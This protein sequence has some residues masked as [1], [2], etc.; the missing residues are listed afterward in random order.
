MKRNL[1]Q[2]SSQVFDLL[3]IGGGIYGVCI[4]WDA[5][6]RGLSVA[7]VEKGDF[8][9]ATSANSLRVIHGGLRY[10]QH[11][12][13]PRM[14]QSIRERT[15]FMQIAPHLVQPFPIVIPTYGHGLRGR[16]IFSLALSIDNLVGFDRNRLKDP[17][18][19]LPG[20][21]LL[22][23]EECIRRFPYVEKKRLTGGVVVYDCQMDSS[24][25]LVLSLARSAAAAGAEMANYTEVTELTSENSRVT[26]V[27]ARDALTGNDEFRIRAKVTVNASGPWMDHV[28]GLLP[29]HRG[30]PRLALSRAFN[31]LIRR[32]VIPRYAVGVYG[33]TFYKDSDAF[34]RKGSR[35]YFI[36]P[37]RD[38]SLIGTAHLPH[39]GDPNNVEVTEIEI[40]TFLSDLNKGCQSI[41]LRR[42]DVA[43]VYAGLLPMASYGREGIQLVKH[44]RLYDHRAEGLDGLISVSGV[45]FTE[46]RRVAEKVVNKTFVHLGKPSPK[47]STAVTPVHGGEIERFGT[48]VSQAIERRPMGLSAD[49]TRDLVHNY[50]SAY[51]EILQYLDSPCVRIQPAFSGTAPAPSAPSMPTKGD[52]DLSPV[53]G[54]LVRHA[55]RDEMAKK[56]SDLV[57]RR[58]WLGNTANI[59]PAHLRT[60]AAVMAHELGWHSIKAQKELEDVKSMMASDPGGESIGSRDGSE[61]S[62][63]AAP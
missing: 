57:F 32:E 63:K 55:V 30:Q 1:A 60:C 40:E 14:R 15:V 7:L 44:P 12:D 5:A 52:E 22:S 54:A 24:E 38:R 20:G 39:D 29:G 62:V 11:G 18:K 33:Q 37:W 9:H 47:C 19:H 16:E 43:R 31:L 17:N 21:R 26:G 51:H 49:I 58:T 6:L 36:I 42:D 53:L 45:K 61:V 23:K 8:G 4:A 25:R 50:G 46:A 3:V 41:G 2:L 35:L 28:L 48:F 27:K 56:L 34:L 59:G 13:I 10:L